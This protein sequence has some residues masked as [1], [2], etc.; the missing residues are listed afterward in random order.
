MPEVATQ[1]DMMQRDALSRH[2]TA[3][4]RLKISSARRL[5]YEE[6][7]VVD[8]PQVEALLKTESL[9]PTLVRVLIS[10]NETNHVQI[11]CRT[12]FQKGL[13][14]LDSISSSYSLSIYYT[15]LN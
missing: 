6:H 5:I 7:Y 14:T 9:V 3:E 8:T 11:L 13:V 2:D 1:N 15:N 12:H 10:R 4:R